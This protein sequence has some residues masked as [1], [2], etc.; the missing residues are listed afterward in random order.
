VPDPAR[1]ALATDAQDA[2]AWPVAGFS[3][4]GLATWSAG[5]AWL[6][7]AY[8]HRR[9]DGSWDGTTTVFL[10]GHAEWK[11][12]EQLGVTADARLNAR[13]FMW[14]GRGSGDYEDPVWW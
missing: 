2:N 10:D 14:Y 4:P 13:W 12:R 9:R 6:D 7:N 1:I 5:G 11:S 3:W 8:P